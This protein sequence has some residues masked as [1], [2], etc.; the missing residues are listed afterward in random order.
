[1]TVQ[2]LIDILKKLPPNKII[3]V[4]NREPHGH[5]IVAAENVTIGLNEEDGCVIIDDYLED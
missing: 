5:Y 1:M 4:P 2:E 3:M